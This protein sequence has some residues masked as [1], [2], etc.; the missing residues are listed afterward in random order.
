LLSAALISRESDDDLLLHLVHTHHGSGRPFGGPVLENEAA[1]TP[2]RQQLFGFKPDSCH[3]DTLRWNGELPQRFWRVVR[4]FGWWGAAYREAVFRLADHAESRE[5]QEADW[6]PAAKAELLEFASGKQRGC[7]PHRLPLPGLD[8]ANPLAFLA[9]VGTLVICRRLSHAQNRPDWLAGTP[10][11]SWGA[12]G[13]PYV[14]VLHVAAEPPSPRTFAEYLAAQLPQSASNHPCAWVVTMLSNKSGNLVKCIRDQCL[15]AQHVDWPYLDWVIALVS[16]TAPDATSQ[17]QTARRDYLLDNI[18]Q[19]MQ[20]TKAD[21][22]ER[23]LF[24]MW[25]YA[26]PLANQSLHWEPTEDRRHA[27]QWHMPSGDPT[28]KKRGGMLG[29][30][31]LALEAW[32]LFPSF[33]A[34]HAADDRV[35]TRG[36]KGNR[37]Y[38]TYFT[39][40]I[41]SSAL[42]VDAVA[43]LLA[44]ELLQHD[45]PD[46]ADLHGYNVATVFRSQRILVGKTPNLTTARAIG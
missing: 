41:W 38:D 42:A 16:E 15:P 14:P 37:A 9:A 44:L 12:D 46:Y 3:Q 4:K 36:F 13:F 26:D 32:P 25:D 40:P 19:I 11:L 35:T 20:L 17:L 22:L 2:C 28:R 34:D 7:A 24:H 18:R 39:W 43:S 5:E 6:Q 33:A 30:N 21:H 45:E 10:A 8:G 29:A 31:R 27:Y 1:S 23:C